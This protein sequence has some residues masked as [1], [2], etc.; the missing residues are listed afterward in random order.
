MHFPAHRTKTL[1]LHW[2]KGNLRW[3]AKLECFLCEKAGKEVVGQRNRREDTTER[4]L[5][6]CLRMQGVVVVCLAVNHPHSDF[7]CC[8]LT[9][10]P[11]ATCGCATSLCYSVGTLPC[12]WIS[13][14]CPWAAKRTPAGLLRTS[15]RYRHRQG[16]V[17]MNE[18]M[19][20][21]LLGVFKW[22]GRGNWK[23]SE[24]KTVLTSLPT[25]LWCDII[26]FSC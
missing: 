2:D 21:V 18:Y 25:Q 14:L 24:P 16:G 11:S 5:G 19:A 8:L 15:L 1:V 6:R 22:P 23:D 26:V 10:C 12:W 4:C 17:D 9:Q 7:L 3:R 20:S 13:T